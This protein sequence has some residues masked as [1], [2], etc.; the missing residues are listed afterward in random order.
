[1]I[2]LLKASPFYAFYLDDFYTK[3][4]E[5]YSWEYS[6]QIEAILSEGIAW[7]NFWKIN[8]EKTGRYHVEEII[9]TSKH[10][11]TTWAKENKIKYRED[12]WYSDILRAQVQLYQPDIFFPHDYFNINSQ[13]IKELRK[14]TPSIR[15]VLGYDG[16]GLGDAKRFEGT[17]LMISCAKFICEFYADNGYDTWFM[18]FGYETTIN[19]KLIKRKPLYNV[20]FCGSVI[21]RAQFHNERLRML[22]EISNKIPLSLWAASFPKNWQPW[23]KDQLR[24]LKQ[25]KFLEFLDVWNLGK[26]NQGTKSGLEMY[27]CLLDSKIT[28]N[29]HID[30]SGPVAGNSRLMEATG[31]GTCLVTDWKPNLS[32][33]FNPDTEIVTFKTPSEAIDKI[34]YLMNNE[35]ARKKIAEAGNKRTLSEHT[36]EIR[37]QNLHLKIEE[38]LNK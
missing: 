27:Q 26:I 11:Q 5:A 9:T 25:G 12:H 10:L 34:K 30:V 32:E 14:E 17:D 16:Y 1:M 19:S 4:P 8:L 28:L 3:H 15:L 7:A 2:K 22:S 13:F 29:H 23:K 20:S 31:A 6:R 35:E 38:L 21:V 36:F 33:F 18:P 37:M 24:R